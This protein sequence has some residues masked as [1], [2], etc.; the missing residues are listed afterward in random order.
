MIVEPDYGGHNIDTGFADSAGN[1]AGISI[2]TE[3]NM[4]LAVE[5]GFD[6][7]G[8]YGWAKEEK[9]LKTLEK[10]VKIADGKVLVEAG[11]PH[12][13]GL[14]YARQVPY[15]LR[16]LVTPKFAANM[17][18]AGARIVQVPAVGSLPG[19]TKEYVAEI[20]DAVHEQNGLC[21]TG[22]H[23][24]QEGTD[25][26]TIRRIAIDNKS[27]GADI[28]VL[29]DAGLNEN[30]GL[31]ETIQALCIAIKGKRHTYRRLTESVMR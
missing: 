26:S 11:I 6:K 16:E 25:S 3:E 1:I 17:V 23:S 4:K 29:G 28:Q 8:V 7:V 14:I 19:F 12:G 27:L 9:F 31:P 15:N 21:C 24:S 20:I 2:T 10:L 22:I 13:P 30:M 5:Q 18:K